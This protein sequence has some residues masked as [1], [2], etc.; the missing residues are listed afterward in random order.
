MSLNEPLPPAE[1]DVT[2][3]GPVVP[4]SVDAKNRGWRTLLWGLASDVLV[5][6]LLF[7]LPVF[8]SDAFDWSTTDW[9]VLG[10][11]LAKTVVVAALSYIARVL[12]LS[13]RTITR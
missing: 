4:A 12:G 9:K 13:A 8:S 3:T 5:V 7:L 1:R 11:S 2:P 10:F 6:I